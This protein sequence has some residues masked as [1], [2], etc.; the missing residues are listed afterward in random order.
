MANTPYILSNSLSAGIVNW[1]VTNPYFGGFFKTINNYS[2]ID[3]PQSE[4]TAVNVFLLP[5]NTRSKPSK[6]IGKVK[7]VISFN[8]AEQR[9][10]KALQIYQILNMV[11]VQLINNP[12]YL[13]QYLSKN[14]TPGLQLI[15]ST[16]DI[17]FSAVQA[18]LVKNSGSIS[19][20][21]ILDYQISILL[22]QRAL[23]ALGNDYFSPEDTV[24]HRIEEINVTTTPDPYIN[25]NS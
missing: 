22:N 16:N 12:N 5:T 20:P 11:R 9:A 7:I 2:R 13:Q 14:Y 4:L 3:N 24:Y 6:E 19:I 8:L 21:I 15:Q 1:F 25:N 18:Q 17:D 10:E 23:W